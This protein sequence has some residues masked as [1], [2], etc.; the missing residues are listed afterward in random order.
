M[1]ELTRKYYRE[2]GLDVG[3]W[4]YSFDSRGTRSNSRVER[5]RLTAGGQRRWQP[6]PDGYQS[7]GG[8]GFPMSKLMGFVMSVM[9]VLTGSVGWAESL[10]SAKPDE[11]GLSPER[12]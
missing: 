7:V 8:G 12:L 1:L 9:L 3:S 5:A 6:R 2:V 4:T 10:P 11:V